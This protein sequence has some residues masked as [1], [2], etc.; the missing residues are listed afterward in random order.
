MKDKLKK[1]ERE[2]HKCQPVGGIQDI[3]AGMENIQQKVFRLGTRA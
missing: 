3:T 1:F 2:H